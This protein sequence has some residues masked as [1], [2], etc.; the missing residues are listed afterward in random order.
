[1]SYGLLGEG[2]FLNRRTI[3]GIVVSVSAVILF[4]VHSARKGQAGK[5]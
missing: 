1:L 4:T 3:L 2:Q 5:G